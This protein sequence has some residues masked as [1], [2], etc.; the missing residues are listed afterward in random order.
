M[1][2]CCLLDKHL[3]SCLFLNMRLFWSHDRLC[4]LLRTPNF[5]AFDHG[6]VFHLFAL[7]IFVIIC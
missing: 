2:E 4:Q 1:I 3:H 6:S 5:S 7:H